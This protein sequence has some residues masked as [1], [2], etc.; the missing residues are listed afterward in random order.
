MP[1]N[2]ASK[3][4]TI[5]EVLREINDLVQEDTELNKNI[6]SKLSTAEKM[7]KRMSRKLVEYNQEVFKNWWDENPDY[8]ADLERRLSTFY[9][10]DETEK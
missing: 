4:I 8:K 6:R 5:C 2:E 9:I 3:F 7:A 1:M 10:I